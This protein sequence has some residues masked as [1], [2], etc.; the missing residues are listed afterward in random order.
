MK[1]ILT[2]QIIACILC[3]T[4]AAS[5]QQIDTTLNEYK[6]LYQS[7]GWFLY[8]CDD[9][10]P[11][12]GSIGQPIYHFAFN[13][14]NIIITQVNSHFPQSAISSFSYVPI[15]IGIGET[16]SAGIRIYN[17]Y[18][19]L[20]EQLKGTTKPSSLINHIDFKIIIKNL[21]DN[22]RE[23]ELI[24]MSVEGSYQMKYKNKFRQNSTDYND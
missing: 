22:Q 1:T 6:Y 5:C 18:Y 14:R 8:D 11:L 19:N 4:K 21:Y 9:P 16:A 12:E 24:L 2:I 3:I 17:T 13:E 15:S 10:H 7:S 20:Y 23:K